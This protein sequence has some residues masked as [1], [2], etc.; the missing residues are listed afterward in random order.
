MGADSL[1]LRGRKLKNL[2]MI[3]LFTILA[4]KMKKM[5]KIQ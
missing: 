1:S 3:G 5:L 2:R 4:I